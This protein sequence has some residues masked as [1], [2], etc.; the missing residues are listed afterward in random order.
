MFYIKGLSIPLSFCFGRLH[1]LAGID[2]CTLS[3]EVYEDELY[4]RGRY[5]G[6]FQACLQ[7]LD[8][9]RPETYPKFS[10]YYR[11]ARISNILKVTS[12]MNSS[13]L[14]VG[15]RCS[16]NI[17]AVSPHRKMAGSVGK[18]AVAKKRQIRQVL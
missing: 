10:I 16:L 1:F 11:A 4:A 6:V 13:E 12:R 9:S 18:I 2:Y 7:S 17:V 15:F 5:I 8:A 3:Y 14:T